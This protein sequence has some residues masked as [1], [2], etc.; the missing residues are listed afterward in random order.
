VPGK[1]DE[2]KR[3]A[4]RHLAGVGDMG[5]EFHEWTGYAY[6]L[7]RRLATEEQAAI[8]P[9]VDCRG[10]EEGVRRYNAVRSMLSSA[11]IALAMEELS[12][13]AHA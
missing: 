12:E 13:T 2:L 1:R 5:A 6:H 10:T 4:Y 9:A 3:L 11:G 7:R 8:G